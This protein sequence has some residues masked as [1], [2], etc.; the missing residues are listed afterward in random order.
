MTTETI[1]DYETVEKEKEI[2]RCDGPGC[3]HTDE[4]VTLVNVCINPKVESIEKEKTI[5]IQ[6]FDDVHDRDATLRK[7][8]AS[9][10]EER[11]LGDLFKRDD[12]ISPGLARK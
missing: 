11:E 7:K 2:T 10:R 9:L 8:Q 1:T 3:T 6:T 5:P 4:D 12:S